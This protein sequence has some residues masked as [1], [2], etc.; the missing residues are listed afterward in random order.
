MLKRTG[1]SPVCTEQPAFVCQ[2]KVVKLKGTQEQNKETQN[3]QSRERQEE[4]LW[5]VPVQARLVAP[6]QPTQPFSVSVSHVTSDCV[7]TAILGHLCQ[8]RLSSVGL[9]LGCGSV[10]QPSV[11]GA[12]GPRFPPTTSS[13]KDGVIWC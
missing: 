5:R 9:C 11:L 7:G 3:E 2:V 1:M 10:G 4:G 8:S 6:R 12:E 13:L